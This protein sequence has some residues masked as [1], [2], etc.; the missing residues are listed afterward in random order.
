MK[1]YTP[2][3]L[4]LILYHL[5]IGCIMLRTIRPDLWLMGWD[6][7]YPEL[8]IPLNF[9]R[10]LSA[11]WQEYYGNGLVGGHGFAATLPHT[12]IISVLS[13]VLPQQLLRQAF[14][15]LCYY[16]G[17]LGTLYATRTLL[18]QVFPKHSNEHLFWFASLFAAGY[19]LL[20]LGTI[21]TF[22]LPLESFT[23]HYAVI[24]W[25][26][27][28]TLRILHHPTK[29]LYTWYFITA[30]LGSIQGFVPA[31]FIAYI[32]SLATTTLA[33]AY[34]HKTRQIIL[35]TIGILWL[36]LFAAN[37]YWLGPVAYF[38]IHGKSDYIAAYNNM[39]STPK[40]EALSQ[41]YGDLKDVALLKG[42]LWESNELGGPIMKPWIDHQTHPMVPTLGYLFFGVSIVGTLYILFANSSPIAKG[43]ALSLIATV[44]TLAVDTPPFSYFWTPIQY[45]FPG[46]AQAFRTTFTK[47]APEAGLHISVL[48]G[49]GIVIF[50]QTVQHYF[51][52]HTQR[53]VTSFQLALCIGLLYYAFPAFQSSL[54]FEKL[55]VP[56]PESYLSVMRNIN[57]LPYGK[58]ADFPQDCSE[59]WYNTHWG[60]FGSGFLWYGVNK[61][62]MAR[63]FDVWSRHNESYYWEITQALRQNDYSQIE[64][65]FDKYNIQYVYYDEN[66]THCSSQKGFFSS[67]EFSN[68]I[69]SSANYTQIFSQRTDTTLPISFYTRTKSV[70]QAIAVTTS[71]PSNLLPAYS[72]TDTDQA[73]AHTGLYISD[74]DL[75]ADLNTPVV[76][77]SKRGDAIDPYTNT[78]NMPSVGYASAHSLTVI[79]C[80]QNTPMDASFSHTT[81]TKDNLMRLINTNSSLCLST[82]FHSLDTSL[83]YALRITTRHIT[84]EPLRLSVTNKGRP[85]GIDIPIFSSTDT[86]TYTYY[87]PPTFPSEISYEIR[88]QNNSYAT[89]TSINDIG[90]IS[91]YPAPQTTAFSN[92]NMHQT[93]LGALTYRDH[94]FPW[95]YR[96]SLSNSD[97]VSTVVLY[98][99]YDDGWMAFMNNSRLSK[100]YQVN[101]W[102]NGWNTGGRS[103]EMII[104]FVPQL[105]EYAGLLGI[106]IVGTVLVIKVKKGV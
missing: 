55:F 42:Y 20:N 74:D 22:Y 78:D 21:Q 99:T 68:Y 37:L 89:Q 105:L 72:I 17:G 59:G 58:I 49:V 73:F 93:Q 41:K 106:L 60:Y 16:A 54:I 86:D 25:L 7:L 90:D 19:Y 9:I 98:Q 83:P 50:F 47:F 29:Q 23:A 35:R 70:P 43:V 45:I 76:P 88:I 56:L 26:L 18:A 44:G 84:G 69:Q 71:R 3:T 6:G 53:I 27:Y 82:T 79:P 57:N 11:G 39:T 13:I 100:H 61:P 48:L 24:S 8:N 31:V 14:I 10:G 81:A 15:L 104:V 28:L 38:S 36:L 46:V 103:G 87:I 1:R 94:P 85:T 95:L 32:I 65:I 96:F 66:L 4:A 77:F 91:L 5:L 63:P 102:A 75:P 30:L 51:K 62:F 101:S 40:F 92:Q 97:P 2:K 64:R 67:R 52:H 33:V 34:L 80:S 12:A